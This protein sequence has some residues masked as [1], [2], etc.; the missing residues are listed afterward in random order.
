MIDKT[1]YETKIMKPKC[2][3]LK[4]LHQQGLHGHPK[5]SIIE[6]RVDKDGTPLDK[7][8][9]RRLKDSPI[10]GCVEVVSEKKTSKKDKE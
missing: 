6:V 5:G 1:F 9:R 7:H 4:I 8:W 3:K 2:I 10:D